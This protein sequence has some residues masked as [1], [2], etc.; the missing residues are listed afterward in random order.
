MLRYDVLLEMDFARLLGS[1]LGADCQ[2]VV[3]VGADYCE[4]IDYCEMCRSLVHCGLLRN[5][6][7]MSALWTTAKRGDH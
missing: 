2:D 7:I 5:V 6:Q 4:I 3:S 1:M